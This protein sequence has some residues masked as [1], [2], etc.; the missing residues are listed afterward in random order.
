MTPKHRFLYQGSA[1]ECLIDRVTNTTK[2]IWRNDAGAASAPVSVNAVNAVV[3]WQNSHTTAIIP[4]TSCTVIIAARFV[5]AAPYNAYVRIGNVLKLRNSNV[6]VFWDDCGGGNVNLTEPG[7]G[8]FAVTIKSPSAM[9][10][11][12]TGRRDRSMQQTR[13]SGAS[14]AINTDPI[15]IG[16]AGY[17]SSYG[18]WDLSEM[19]YY[20]TALSVDTA[21]AEMAEMRQRLIGLGLNVF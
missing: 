2:G 13:T 3:G 21:R 4:T 8:V 20:D 7:W 17:A 5:N 11:I 19:R 12:A 9:T 10:Y 6:R 14:I 16:G 1:A 15:I 18:D